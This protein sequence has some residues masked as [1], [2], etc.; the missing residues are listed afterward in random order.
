MTNLNFTTKLNNYKTAILNFFAEQSPNFCFNFLTK[1]EYVGRMRIG[2]REQWSGC[3]CRVQYFENHGKAYVNGVKTDKDFNEY[4]DAK[5]YYISFNAYNDYR[6]EKSELGYLSISLREDLIKYWA[7]T[8]TEN[9]YVLFISSFNASIYEMPINNIVDFY[10]KNAD[11]CRVSYNGFSDC[12]IPVSKETVSKESAIKNEEKLPMGYDDHFYKPQYIA[13]FVYSVYRKGTAVKV[14]SFSKSGKYIQERTFRSISEVYDLLQKFH[15][16]SKSKKTLQRH[17][18]DEMVIDLDNGMK[19][20]ITTDVEKSFKDVNY[21]VV[22][23]IDEYIKNPLFNEDQPED[24]CNPKKLPS[25][26]HF[27]LKKDERENWEEHFEE[28]QEFEEHD[29]EEEMETRDSIVEIM[30]ITNVKEKQDAYIKALAEFHKKL[31]MDIKAERPHIADYVEQPKPVS[32][33]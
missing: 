6:G 3:H 19:I 26:R 28:I 25:K 31:A 29:D 2:T 7:Q 22:E 32:L 14:V 24:S 20:F 18:A 13:N 33:F 30:S 17:V 27:E 9:R 21:E 23:V 11:K 12:I 15:C 4:K 10:I 1:N 16:Y 8:E 5:A